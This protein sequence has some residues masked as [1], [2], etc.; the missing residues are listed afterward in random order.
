MM[1]KILINCLSPT[2]VG[3]EDQEQQLQQL[4]LFDLVHVMRAFVVHLDL[5]PTPPVTRSSDNAPPNLD[6]TTPNNKKSSPLRGGSSSFARIGGGD[7]KSGGGGNPGLMEVNEMDADA[8]AD[9]E[10]EA[11]AL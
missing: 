11:E 7:V 3:E 1:I 10:P 9:A 4:L 8:D 2:L 5:R 6:G